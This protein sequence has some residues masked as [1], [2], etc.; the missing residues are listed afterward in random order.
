MEEPPAD[1][2]N[3]V[4]LQNEPFFVEEPPLEPATV[5]VGLAAGRGQAGLAEQAVGRHEPG[6]VAR[7]V[8]RF[9][10]AEQAAPR[11]AR[12]RPLSQRVPPSAS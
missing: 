1:S 10:H 11:A 4:Q 2:A 9:E 7:L 5:G 6:R 12:D 3:L 8:A